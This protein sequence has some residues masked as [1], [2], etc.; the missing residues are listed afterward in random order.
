MP[1]TLVIVRGKYRAQRW[2]I[3]LALLAVR[4]VSL[5]PS[6]TEIIAALGLAEQLVGRSHECNYP[7]E[8]QALPVVSASRIDTL[9][10]RER[11]D[12]PRRARR[13]RRRPPALRGRRRPA[14][15]ARARRDRDP[16]SVRGL[17]RLERRGQAR[18]AHGRRDDLARSARPAARSR[19]RSARSRATSAPPARAS[20]SRRRCTTAS[21]GCTRP[22]AACR[23][24]ACSWPSGST[25]RSPPGT[26]CPRWSRSRA[27]TRCSGARASARSPRPGRPSRR[28]LRSSSCSRPAASTSSARSREAGAVPA[29]GARVVAVDGDA[30]YSRPG[31]RVAEGVAQLAHLLHPDAVEAPRAARRA[32]WFP[33]ERHIC[34]ARQVTV[35][36]APVSRPA[37]LAAPT[38]TGHSVLGAPHHGAPA[39][40]R[41]R[42]ADAC[43]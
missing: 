36:A 38:L 13:A 25:R 30:A 33:A 21:T 24:S 18:R 5:V 14:R 17:R 16:G 35:L 2:R 23:A 43:S 37:P 29:M 11:R 26:G 10:D 20:S 1:L 12:R 6:A 41:R 8:V 9:G 19:S 15:A 22:C 32:S 28:R 31:P 4:V 39:R 27:A 34:D 3:L 42:R 7:P 40:R